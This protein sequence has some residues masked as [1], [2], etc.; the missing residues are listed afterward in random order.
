MLYLGEFDAMSQIANPLNTLGNYTL[1][2]VRADN[3]WQE[4]LRNYYAG[5]S[6]AWL[7]LLRDQIAS[8]TS[9]KELPDQLQPYPE[10]GLLALRFEIASE[11]GDSS[12][13]TL[14]RESPGA[15]ASAC[16]D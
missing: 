15:N 1:S 7:K 8:M 5:A 9:R 11:A 10:V 13:A 3:R 12:A 2:L 4:T 14:A 16:R 6:S